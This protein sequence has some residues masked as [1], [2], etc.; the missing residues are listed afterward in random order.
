MREKAGAARS[1]VRFSKSPEHAKRAPLD[2]STSCCAPPSPPA[3]PLQQ[4]QQRSSVSRSPSSDQRCRTPEEAV[5]LRPRAPSLPGS[6]VDL[7]VPPRQGRRPGRSA[8]GTRGRPG[9]SFAQRPPHA[10]PDAQPGMHEGATQRGRRSPTRPGQG[11]GDHSR[12]RSPANSDTFRR[13][14]LAV[15][16][17]RHHASRSPS[18]SETFARMGSSLGPHRHGASRSPSNSETFRRHGSG[19]DARYQRSRSPTDSETYLRRPSHSGL[20]DSCTIRQRGSSAF[21]SKVQRSPTPTGLREAESVHFKR[22]SRSPSGPSREASVLK[23]KELASAGRSG[24]RRRQHPST[25]APPRQDLVRS[26]RG[27]HR[28]SERRWGEHRSSWHPPPEQPLPR[29]PAPTENGACPL[30]SQAPVRKLS[31]SDIASLR[32]PIPSTLSSAVSRAA[33]PPQLCTSGSSASSGSADMTAA[34]NISAP[35]GGQLSIDSPPVLL[36]QSLPPQQPPAPPPALDASGDATADSA[37]SAGASAPDPAAA[38]PGLPPRAAGGLHIDP[39]AAAACSPS[40][41]TPT[42]EIKY[43]R[44]QSATVPE[45][46]TLRTSQRSRSASPAERGALTDTQPAPTQQRELTSPV[47]AGRTRRSCTPPVM[48]TRTQA[49]VVRS[50][51]H[52]PPVSPSAA[53]VPQ[54][55]VSN[56]S[57]GAP[58]RGLSATHA[59]AA[60]GSGP[61]S[62]LSQGSLSRHM[63]S[64]SPTLQMVQSPQWYPHRRAFVAAAVRQLRQG[65]EQSADGGDP[66]DSGDSARLVPT[67]EEEAALV[68]RAFMEG[69]L[70]ER[71]G[72]FTVTSVE[73]VAVITAEQGRAAA[74]LE[75]AQDGTQQRPVAA[76]HGITA[77]PTRARIKEMVAEGLN[78]KK[79]KSAMF[80]VGAYIAT[81]GA[82]AYMY[83]FNGKWDRRGGGVSERHSL[84]LVVLAGVLCP[85]TFQIGQHSVQHGCVT[86]DSLREPTQFCVPSGQEHRLALTHVLTLQAERPGPPGQSGQTPPA[87]P[88]SPPLAPRSPPKGPLL[89]PPSPVGSAPR[90]PCTEKLECPPPASDPPA[91]QDTPVSTGIA[92]GSPPLFA[93][94]VPLLRDPPAHVDPAPDAPAIVG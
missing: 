66:T 12:S 48:P 70:A 94:G 72:N 49:P 41:E 82:K 75:A 5:L 55:P 6:I 28:Q 69:G 83:A 57:M 4:Q 25:Q 40:K 22:S 2:Q 85:G 79:C 38:D 84:P 45:A 3:V 43:R 88:A 33:L 23:R 65:A 80:G 59:R 91:G 76:F 64:K 7:Q 17:C 61:S 8:A 74:F 87:S 11:H 58:A 21:H 10:A 62:P 78:P 31:V 9:S 63:R 71:P 37:N 77:A 15:E 90:S 19:L 54:S 47:T 53:K 73:R 44:V 67:T 42:A 51:G 16:A 1:R 27:S 52:R 86:A 14:P 50:Q 30:K 92:C 56:S 60:P 26:V 34:T 36:H 18:Q 46:P 35:P 89:P 29:P 93:T 81:N 32:E 39:T 24:S 13:S 68:I 20:R